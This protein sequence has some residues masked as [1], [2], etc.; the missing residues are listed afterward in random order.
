M[1][2]KLVKRCDTITNGEHASSTFFIPPLI[3]TPYLLL[4]RVIVSFDILLEDERLTK[5]EQLS[6]SASGLRVAGDAFVFFYKKEN[7]I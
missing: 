3:T 7:K 6:L 4:H 5:V 1:R 2:V